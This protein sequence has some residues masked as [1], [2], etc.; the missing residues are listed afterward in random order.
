MKNTTMWKRILTL[1]IIALL[2]TWTTMIVWLIQFEQGCSGRLKRAADANTIGI[3][4][5]ELYD[6]VEYLERNNMTEG[7]TSIIYKTPNEDVGFFYKNLK[8]S[9]NELCKI[10]EDS[11]TQLEKTNV[12]MKLR[13]TI[14]DGDSI[15]YP[16]GI[17][18]FPYNKFLFFFQI[19]LVFSIIIS[20]LKS[21]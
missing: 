11:A 3:A 14:M 15:T 7:Y 5:V 18:R 6:A 20:F 12:L 13:E 16:W 17:S 1:S 21:L 4:K 10:N 8:E 9:Y 19:F 2:T